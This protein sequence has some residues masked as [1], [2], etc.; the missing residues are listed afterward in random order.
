MEVEIKKKKTSNIFISTWGA[1]F[2]KLNFL[3]GML[4]ALFLSLPL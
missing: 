1:Y 2:L 4:S 3:K